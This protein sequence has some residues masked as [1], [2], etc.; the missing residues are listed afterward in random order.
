MRL[1]GQVRGRADDHIPTVVGEQAALTV[2]V[3]P[4]GGHVGDMEQDKE[5]FK[6]PPPDVDR[7]LVIA[8]GQ[9][10]SLVAL[11]EVFRRLAAL[12]L[13]DLQR[14]LVRGEGDEVAAVRGE[15]AQEAGWLLHVDHCEVGEDV[16]VENTDLVPV[17]AGF[18]RADPAALQAVDDIL[19]LDAAGPDC[20]GIMVHGQSSTSSSPCRGESTHVPWDYTETGGE[21]RVLRDL[22]AELGLG[23]A[24]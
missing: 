5:A 10:L 2:Q 15:L 19:V 9:D 14:G 20:G 17:G 16:L 1:L 21:F 18:A 6:E 4:V 8:V 22:L 3:L 12:I 13:V 23:K 11:Q 24:P 7:S